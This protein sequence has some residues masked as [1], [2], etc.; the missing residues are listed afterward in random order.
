MKIEVEVTPAQAA[1]INTLAACLNVTP[2]HLLR[3]LA[4]AQVD[5]YNSAE[6]FLDGWWADRYAKK[7]FDGR[8]RIEDELA[9]MLNVKKRKTAA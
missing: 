4:L 7:A 6:E 1:R 2:G 5:G 8:E 3:S 9:D